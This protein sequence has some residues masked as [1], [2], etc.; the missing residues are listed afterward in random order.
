MLGNIP[1]LSNRMHTV[2]TNNKVVED[3]ITKA[4]QW[5]QLAKEIINKQA[6]G[7]LQPVFRKGEKVWL[8]GKN[9]TLPYVTAKLAPKHFGPFMI[10]KEISPVAY[11]LE[12]P[13][14]WKIHDM[15]HA[16]LLIA[17]QETEQ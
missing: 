1:P 4:K 10:I 15:F 16:S 17:Y 3:R 9:L 5:Q 11:Q 13:T 8:K 7:P 6:K 12:L 14:R 2:E